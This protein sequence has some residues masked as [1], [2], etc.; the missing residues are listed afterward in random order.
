MITALMCCRNFGFV[1]M[2]SVTALLAVK[3]RLQDLGVPE[4]DAAGMTRYVTQV[5]HT[6]G[7]SV[8]QWRVGETWS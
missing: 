2:A 3:R 4:R 7:L 8:N 1:P 6:S 5:W